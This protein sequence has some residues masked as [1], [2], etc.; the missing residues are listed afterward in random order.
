M[1]EVTS[2]PTVKTVLTGDKTAPSK[3]DPKPLKNPPTPLFYVCSIGLVTIPV[4]P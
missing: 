4:T 2:V 3:P 1:P